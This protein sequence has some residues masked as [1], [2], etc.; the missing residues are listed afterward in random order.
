MLWPETAMPFYFEQ[1]HE[2]ADAIRRFA[3]DN[4][5]YL[6]FGAPAVVRD[7]H[8][9]SLRNR[10]FLLSK[11]G[12]T[13]GFYDKEHLVPFGEYTPFG[14]A[15]PLI[16]DILQG[17]DFSPGRHNALL[18]LQGRDGSELLLGALIC[19]EAIFPALAQARVEQGAAILINVSNDGWFRKSSAPFQHLAHAVLRC[20]EQSRPLARATNTGITAA[21]DPFGRITARLDGLFVDGSLST[22]ITPGR[23][24]TT[25]HRLRPLPEI[26]LMALAL[27]SLVC[28]RPSTLLSIFRKPKH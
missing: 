25:Y 4:G 27:F 11:S 23:G 20:V 24:I 3:A 21:I 26:V 16:R 18:R 1:Q 12:L 22:T 7:S 6:A 10:L 9:R 15:I 14:T 17:M 5:I 13:T 8:H 2:Y 28:Y 19:Y